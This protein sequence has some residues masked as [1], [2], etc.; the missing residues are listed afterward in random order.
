MPVIGAIHRIKNGPKRLSSGTSALP[1]KA[2]SILSAIAMDLKAIWEMS[3]YIACQDEQKSSSLGGDLSKRR[4]NLCF[5]PRWE[6][7]Y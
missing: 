5:A 7:S 2:D 4:R 1:P 3:A 6:R